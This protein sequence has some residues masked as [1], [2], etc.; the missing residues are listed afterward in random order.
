MSLYWNTK[1][2]GGRNYIVVKHPLRDISTSAYGVKFHCGYGVVEKGSKAYQNLRTMPVFR[3]AQEFPL[4]ILKTLKFV[5]RS[6]DIETIYGK[7]VYISYQRALLD[8]AKKQEEQ[9]FA[10]VAA[11][12]NSE[13]STKCKYLLLNNEFC[14]NEKIAGGNYCSTHIM[15]DTELLTEL[16]VEIP[17]SFG[18]PGFGKESAEFVAKICK[19]IERCS[20]DK[21]RKELQEILET[22]SDKKSE[23]VNE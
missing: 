16:G 12:R 3:A 8:H 14:S 19:K 11:E 5:V 10:E 1:S 15:N 17:S 20:R 23:V 22:N 6:K 4:T 7:D 13:A 18:K 2:Y 21:K 9:K